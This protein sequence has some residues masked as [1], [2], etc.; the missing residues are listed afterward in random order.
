MRFKVH[1][2]LYFLLTVISGGMTVFF[3]EKS[4]FTFAVLLLII[5]LFLIQYTFQSIFKI[6]RD[7]DDFVEAVTYRDFTKRYPETGR[8]RNKYYKYFNMVSD[9]FLAMSR[10]KEVQHQYLK[11]ILEL[12][13]TGILAYN[14]DTLD[15]L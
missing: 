13:N 12:V 11:N 6:F 1:F 14:M 2:V 3:F 7:I 5:T 9:T 15:T 10:E 8:T 4:K